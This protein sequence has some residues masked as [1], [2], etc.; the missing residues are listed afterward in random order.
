MP[1]F[2][3]TSLSLEAISALDDDVSEEFLDALDAVDPEEFEAAGPLSFSSR[4]PDTRALPRAIDWRGEKLANAERTRQTAHYGTF[5][6][7]KPTGLCLHYPVHSTWSKGQ[8][9][10]AETE[11]ELVQ[12]FLEGVDRK[13][14]Q[15][16]A[17]ARRKRTY[18]NTYLIIDCLGRVHQD[19][20]ISDQG[21]HGHSANRYTL[22]V[23]ISSAGRLRE[24]DGRFYRVFDVKDG[25]LKNPNRPD[26]PEWARR[27]VPQSSS[28]IVRGTYALFT[29][30]QVEAI[31]ILHA[32]LMYLDGGRGNYQSLHRPGV[33]GVTSHD[34]HKKGKVDVGGSLF[35]DIE[36]LGELLEAYISRLLELGEGALE[37]LIDDD[38]HANAY[39]ELVLS[40]PD[41]QSVYENWR[42]DIPIWA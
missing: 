18:Y 13:M 31:F 33:S 19:C 9:K 38:K 16:L 12:A 39:A 8:V 24:V 30:A 4:E 14:K 28:N 1:T 27:T 10:H 6:E 26:F 35:V 34:V 15:S 17:F 42:D 21:I 5:S 11:E 32:D 20:N 7:E 41:Y 25:R 3:K 40:R 22:G 29:P 23:E 36:T 37:S 2:P